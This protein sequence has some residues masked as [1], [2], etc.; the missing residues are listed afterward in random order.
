MRHERDEI[1]NG[2]LVSFD[3]ANGRWWNY[4][5]FAEADAK[6]ADPWLS[7]G[8]ALRLDFVEDEW[9]LQPAVSLTIRPGGGHTVSLSAGR[10]VRLPS[11][12]TRD[13]RINVA[14]FPF[15]IVA[16]ITDDE[17]ALE[18][19][20]KYQAAYIYDAGDA[21]RIKFALFLN[22]FDDL[23][24]FRLMQ[25]RGERYPFPTAHRLIP[26]ARANDGEGETAGAEV[27]V[28][29]RLAA[30]W[31]L[32]VG[33]SYVAADFKNARGLER[34][35]SLAAQAQ[36]QSANDLNLT[37]D[38]ATIISRTRTLLGLGQTDDLTS[39]SYINDGDIPRHHAHLWVQWSPHTTVD[40]DAIVRYVDALPGGA[41]AYTT[42]DLRV[43]W[44]PNPA[45]ECAV[46]GQNLFAGDRVEARQSLLPIA[47][48]SLVEPG[49]TAS[50]R[51]QF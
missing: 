5:V 36:L 15:N 40:I 7:V 2:Y 1:E 39:L 43:A 9:A 11:R 12:V 28:D 35:H 51:W 42:A 3:D 38:A 19:V 47:T 32:N 34:L 4:Y 48:A 13:S 30:R 18:E 23:Q 26:F 25:P 45:W 14:S 22:Q 21:I 31:R 41:A 49:V 6:I 46:S 10:A 24:S 29:W 33:Y 20:T 50:V 27:W 16:F 37:G 44:R 17:L 8:A